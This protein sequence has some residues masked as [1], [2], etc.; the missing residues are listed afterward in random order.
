ELAYQ[1]AGA[2]GYAYL[3]D[4]DQGLTAP[5][6]EQLSTLLRDIGTPVLILLDEVL[7]HVEAAQTVPAGDSTLGRQLM[8]FLKNLTEAVAGSQNV[9]LVYSLQAS[10]SEAMGAENL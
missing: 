7:N 5:G 3:Q 1:L 6:G 9:V 4:Y 8:V 2:E 10:I